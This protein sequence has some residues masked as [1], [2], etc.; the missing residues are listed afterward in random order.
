LG[1]IGFRVR[2]DKRETRETRE[3]VRGCEIGGLG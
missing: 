2:E 3:V 1:A